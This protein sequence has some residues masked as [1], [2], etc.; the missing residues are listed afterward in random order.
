M[1]GSFAWPA[2]WLW[3]LCLDMDVPVPDE[4]RGAK[5]TAMA[6]SAAL[7]I[8]LA[9][10]FVF[11]GFVAAWFSRAGVTISMVPDSRVNWP[12]SVLQNPHGTAP[13]PLKARLAQWV[14]YP[15]NRIMRHS[16][17]AREFY[18][19]EFQA[20]SGKAV[21]IQMDGDFGIDAIEVKEVLPAR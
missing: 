9:V 21:E 15:A 2:V 3:G 18:M 16:G 17:T 13:G 14:L 11:P 12:W 8:I 10:L 6:L 20:A 4:K 5:G 7:A 19:R 1:N